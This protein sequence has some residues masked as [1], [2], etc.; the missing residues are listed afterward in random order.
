M[1]NNIAFVVIALVFSCCSEHRSE[2]TAN[3]TV[4]E[5]EIPLE[6]TAATFSG[7]MGIQAVSTGP[8]ANSAPAAPSQDVYTN[9]KRVIKIANVRFRVAN[10]QETTAALER[11]II[12]H[13]AYLE[14]SNLG[15]A[16]PLLE[17]KMT[18]RVPND[19]F[20][21]LLK[22][23]DKQGE[24]IHFRTI[25]TDD[26]SK[27]F[28]DLE[29]RLKTKR[30]VEKRYMEILRGK[31]GTVEEVLEAESK[32]GELHEEIEATIARL[33]YL[34]DQVSYSTINLEF[35][36]NIKEQ[37]KVDE[38]DEPGFLTKAG[39]SLGV[40]WRAVQIITLALLQIWP[41]LLFVGGL[42]YFVYRKR[43]QLV[44]NKA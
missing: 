8:N 3:D 1:K 17:S 42:S 24:Y 26:V 28:V 15:Q 18:I 43:K 40:G 32:I 25:T 21:D 20:D 41:L 14:S 37:A 30:E 39:V 44:T 27:D 10:I 29:S 6:E 13:G 36:Q 16:Y 4:A 19:R 35:Y 12:L 31:A 9:S 34:K 22:E 23:L 33:N 38:M 5:D 11:A 2:K 7:T